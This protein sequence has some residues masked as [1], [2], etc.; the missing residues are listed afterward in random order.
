MERWKGICELSSGYLGL[1]PSPWEGAV[2]FLVPGELGALQVGQKP[3]NL[4]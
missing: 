3:S 1:T 2:S 4:C